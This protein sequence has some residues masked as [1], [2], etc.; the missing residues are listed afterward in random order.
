MRQDFKDKPGA[1]ED[2]GS[3]KSGLAWDNQSQFQTL[4]SE[5]PIRYLGKDPKQAVALKSGIR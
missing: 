4:K 5:M 1:S 2:G 3:T